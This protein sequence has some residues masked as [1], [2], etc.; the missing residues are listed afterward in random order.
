MNK[1]AFTL[2]E[3]LVVIAIIGILA[4]VALTSLGPS[5]DKAKDARIIS[6]IN[7]ARIIAEGFYNPILNQYE[8]FNASNAKFTDISTELSNNGGSLNISKQT[9]SYVIY[10]KLASDPNKYYCVDSKGNA[11]IIS[12]TTL[13]NDSCK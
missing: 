13:I 5:R 10:S 3:M 9:T 11:L 1:K 4:A 7:Q 8:D 6:A 12:S 2:I